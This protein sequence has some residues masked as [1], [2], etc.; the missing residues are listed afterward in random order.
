MSASI[1]VVSADPGVAVGWAVHRVEC[2]VLV[3]RG[4]SGS[5]RY[6]RYTSG[7]FRGGSTSENVDQFL[8]VARLAYEEVAQSGDRFAMAVEGFTLRML[9]MDPELLEP[10][11]FNAVLADR[12]RGRWSV[13]WQGASDAINSITDQRLALWGL[14]VN[15]DARHARDARRHGLFYLRRWCGD[16]RVRERAMEV[17]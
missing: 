17:E 4:I 11:R 6:L 8:A 15:K 16:R 13:E 10:V 9:S 1:V 3:D 12:L 2:A 14:L 5:A 7:Q